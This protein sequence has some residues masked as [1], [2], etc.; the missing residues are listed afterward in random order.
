[1]IQST[2]TWTHLLDG[3]VSKINVECPPLLSDYQTSMY[4]VNLSIV[5]KILAK[6]GDKKVYE[7]IGELAP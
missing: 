4:G 1:M 7:I 5:Q 6:R 2:I 3:Y